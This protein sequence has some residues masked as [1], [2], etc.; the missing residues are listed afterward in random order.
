MKNCNILMYAGDHE[1]YVTGTSIATAQVQSQFQFAGNQITK[2][3]EQNLL[4]VNGKKYQAML[5][6]IGGKKKVS[7]SISYVE[8]K[9]LVILIN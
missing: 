1:V 5:L 6:N 7:L 9:L 2:W 8:M 3:Y 4:Q